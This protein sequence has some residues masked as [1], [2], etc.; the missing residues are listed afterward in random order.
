[1]IRDSLI[2]YV[3]Q[4]ISF[5]SHRLIYRSTILCKEYP[6]QKPTFKNPS[7]LKYF[8]AYIL[9]MVGN[10]DP[11]YRLYMENECKQRPVGSWKNADSKAVDEV[12]LRLYNFEK[13]LLVIALALLY[14]SFLI[15]LYIAIIYFK[16]KNKQEKI[17]LNDFKKWE[18]EFE[19]EEIIEINEFIEKFLFNGKVKK[20]IYY[21]PPNALL[22]IL[23]D[24]KMKIVDC[25]K[26]NK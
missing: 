14:F 22:A 10:Y 15:F 1:M 13:R 4:C 26:I 17:D 18:C 12:L 2:C 25:R 16:R 7:K 3:R 19:I 24:G 20:I 6:E 9:A 8:N 5:Q 23:D 21:S 11:L